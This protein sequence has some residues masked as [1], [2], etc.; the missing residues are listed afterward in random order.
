MTAS[1]AYAEST[2]PAGLGTAQTAATATLAATALSLSAA[3]ARGSCSISSWH[4]Q[5][6]F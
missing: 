3:R 4:N 6:S 5:T 2:R 1:R